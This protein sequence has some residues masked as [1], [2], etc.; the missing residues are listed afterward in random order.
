M[1]DNSATQ[2]RPLR[3]LH[4]N[5]YFPGR[6]SGPTYARLIHE[7]ERFRICC[8]NM[9]IEIKRVKAQ[10]QQAEAQASNDRDLILSLQSKI[11][12]L[13]ALDPESTSN[14]SA[15]KPWSGL[16]NSKWIGRAVRFAKSRREEVSEQSDTEETPRDPRLENIF[17]Q[18]STE[19]DLSTLE[20]SAKNGDQPKQQ[21][22]TSAVSEKSTAT[23]CQNSVIS[24][25]FA[26]ISAGPDAIM[27]QDPVFGA[28][29]FIYKFKSLFKRI[30]DYAK[31]YT[32]AEGDWDTVYKVMSDSFKIFLGL[33]ADVRTA[34]L[35]MSDKDKRHLAIMKVINTFVV[36]KV[37]CLDVVRG[38]DKEIDAE[39]LKLAKLLPAKGS[40]DHRRDSI[41]GS[42]GLQL[43]R[44]RNRPLFENF[45]NKRMSDNTGQLYDQISPFLHPMG[46]Q[47]WS[48]LAKI[49]QD[50]HTIALHMHSGPYE[51]GID[52]SPINVRYEDGSPRTVTMN[53]IPT[54]SFRNV[55]IQFPGQ[56]RHVQVGALVL[57][58]EP[59]LGAVPSGEGQQKGQGGISGTRP[60]GV[61][62]PKAQQEGSRPKEPA[63]GPAISRGMPSTRTLLNSRVQGE[64]S[65]RKRI[66]SAPAHLGIF[67]LKEGKTAAMRKTS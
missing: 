30:S 32:K 50:A 38:F 12:E 1:S 7:L 57:G 22:A 35:L 25:P 49:M 40:H 64:T 29:D 61:E 18:P 20:D 11:L 47:A 4:S 67:K 23:P 9:G 44:L 42:M 3:K 28:G 27:V 21:T 59:L 15:G 60:N 52:Y 17:E 63:P 10:L 41:F 5:S 34:C 33:E 54:I 46:T 16:K 24:T 31:S 26:S 36:K 56:L 6:P 48:D 37:L 58:R 65:S 55:N 51:F 62:P 43:L 66:F 2:E 39:I 19:I 45:F 13:Q 8:S 14:K 53:V